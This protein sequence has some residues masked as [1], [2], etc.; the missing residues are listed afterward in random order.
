MTTLQTLKKEWYIFLIALA[1]FIASGVLWNEVPDTVPV[2]YN[3]QGEPDRY[4]YKG[5]LLLLVPGISFGVYLL[6]LFVPAIDPKKKIETNQK[7]IRAVRVITVI[8]MDAVYVVTLA[9]AMGYE[10]DLSMYIMISVG[11][12]F[13]ILGNYMNSIKPNYFIGLRTPWTL[14]NPEVW[15]RTHRLGSKLWM[16]GGIVI[17]ASPFIDTSKQLGISLSMIIIIPLALIPL[18]YSYVIYNQLQKAEHE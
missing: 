4:G 7:A 9:L 5:E 18:I 1:P 17:M 11:A 14:E 16:I 3:F 15:K 10:L 12:L 13:F 2:H 6:L 8:F